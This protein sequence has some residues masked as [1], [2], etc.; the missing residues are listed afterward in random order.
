VKIDRC[1]KI[2]SIV[3]FEVLIAVTTKICR[4]SLTFRRNVLPPFSGSKRNPRKLSVSFFFCFPLLFKFQDEKS[5]SKTSANLYRNKRRH[6]S[7][8]SIPSCFLFS[9]LRYPISPENDEPRT[10]S[11]SFFIYRHLSTFYRPNSYRTSSNS[12]GVPIHFCT[13]VINSGKFGQFNG[14]QPRQNPTLYVL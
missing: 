6:V 7:Q 14:L 5:S 11:Y 1:F 8:N 9:H 10:V 3:E 12:H 4:R 2:F 13:A